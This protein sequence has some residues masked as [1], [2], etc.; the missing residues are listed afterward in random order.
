MSRGST[1]G[2]SLLE[3]NRVVDSDGTV[4]LRLMGEVDPWMAAHVRDESLGLIASNHPVAVD[5]RDVTYLDP[6][7]V[8][9]LFAI[10]RCLVAA[11][12]PRLELRNPSGVVIRRLMESGLA[13]GFRL[14]RNLR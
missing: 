2:V 3:S 10:T 13:G 7:C 14:E 5:L 8:G 6:D 12:R 4:V 1:T 9:P 11:D